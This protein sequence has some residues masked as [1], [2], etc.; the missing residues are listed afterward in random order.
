MGDI[1]HIFCALALSQLWFFHSLSR[2]II[3]CVE[4]I[5][6]FDLKIKISFSF[7]R[8]IVNMTWMSC[9]SSEYVFVI[10]TGVHR[11]WWELDVRVKEREAC[12]YRMHFEHT[13]VD[14][15]FRQQ[16]IIFKFSM[17]FFSARY[18][19]LNRRFNT[20]ALR[21]NVLR[22]ALQNLICLNSSLSQLKII[23]RAIESIFR[24]SLL[25]HWYKRKFRIFDLCSTQSREP[26]M[27][28]YFIRFLLGWAPVGKYE[29]VKYVQCV[30]TCTQ[31]WPLLASEWNICVNK[32]TISKKVKTKRYPVRTNSELMC[33]IS[34]EIIY[35]RIHVRKKWKI[36][37]K[38]AFNLEQLKWNVRKSNIVACSLLEK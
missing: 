10:G 34:K 38:K 33:T 31:P 24:D 16:L 11:C 1:V 15:P 29:W 28:P 4:W 21:Q 13:Y 22:V 5:T 14:L 35:A 18:S 32:K 7:R 17:T 8:F 23:C 9:S 27:E 2:A 30:I 6:W 20:F 37:L 3:M 26:K 25:I 12:E 36:K 19:A